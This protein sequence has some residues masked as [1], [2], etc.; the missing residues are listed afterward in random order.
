MPNDRADELERNTHTDE[1]EDKWVSLN[2]DGE[3]TGAG[4]SEAA[5]HYEVPITYEAE[6]GSSG[7]DEDTN[8]EPEFGLA[9]GELRRRWRCGRSE[10]RGGDSMFSCRRRGK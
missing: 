10:G 9:I 1:D 6:D 8:P 3:E 5:V 4:D 2:E 7:A